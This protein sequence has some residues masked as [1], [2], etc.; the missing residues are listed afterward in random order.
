MLCL[1]SFCLR[2]INIALTKFITMK[3]IHAIIVLCCLNLVSLA[4]NLVLFDS[5]AGVSVPV[6]NIVKSDENSFECE[7]SIPALY[8]EEVLCENGD[9]YIILQFAGSSTLS[10]VGEPSLPVLTK[11]IG[12]PFAKTCTYEIIEKKWQ[13]IQLNKKIYPFQMPLREAEVHDSF[14]IS[15]AV[16]DSDEYDTPICSFG[17]VQKL[18][19]VYNQSMTVCPFRYYPASNKLSVLSDFTL[20]VKFMDRGLSKT[21]QTMYKKHHSDSVYLK[22]C[23]YNFNNRL[24]SSYQDVDYVEDEYD[25]LIIS[26]PDQ[27][28][29]DS[30]ALSSFCLWKRLKGYDCRVYTTDEVGKE[31]K[32]IKDFIRSE[33]QKGVRY[34]LFIGDDKDIPLYTKCINNLVGCAKSDY[35]YGCI[36]GDSD[37]QA[38]LAIG[39]FPVSTL[40]D[41]EIMVNKTIAYEQGTNRT[42]SFKNAL[43]VAHKEGAPGKYQGC[44]ET[45]R[46]T[47]YSDDCFDF[48]PVYGADSIDGGNNANNQTVIDAINAG[49]GIVNYRGHGNQTGWDGHWS[50]EVR[51]FTKTYLD[52]IDIRQRWPVVFSVACQN[53]DISYPSDCL[54]ESFMKD[55]NGAVAF[56]G[57]TESSFTDANNVF[58]ILLFDAICNRKVYNIGDINNLAQII[59]IPYHNYY[60]IFNAYSYL[61]GGDPSLEIWTDEMETFDNAQVRKDG[62]TVFVDAGVSG[63]CKVTVTTNDG[64]Y[65]ESITSG[66]GVMF[67]APMVECYVSL[68]KHN[69]VPK[70]YRLSETGDL[71]IQ[72]EV[73]SSSFEAQAKRVVIGENVISN[74]SE[75]KVVIKKDADVRIKASDTVT[76]ES[77]FS[78]EKGATLRIN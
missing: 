66:S 55:Y 33:Y 37:N 40:S 10:R 72:D 64:L 25:Y 69:Y 3:R 18:K 35:W 48:I 77:G 13:D 52:D 16:Y 42:G 44:C 78:C 46:D 39:R 32:S 70:I 7:V 54:L 30:K 58:N 14:Y 68:N 57:A 4:Q 23:F 50:Y 24:Y 53:G 11:L 67:Q 38:D 2:I 43:L 76:I 45:I 31:C 15:S 8:A 19:G 71:F 49:V 12:I 21:S 9:I 22:E 29:L 56:L 60:A 74:K 34:V 5:K 62:N 63:D 6:F 17:E 73:I 1:L 20:K 41:L 61:W 28:I 36:D 47:V 59:N 75:G 26:K 65:H 51:S 27:S